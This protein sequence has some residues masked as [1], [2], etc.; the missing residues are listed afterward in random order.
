[1]LPEDERLNQARRVAIQHSEGFGIEHK[2]WL[3]LS[4]PD[5]QVKL[6]RAILALRN[7]DGGWL[8]IGVE[9]GTG[10]TAKNP[11]SNLRVSY[12]ADAIN[13]LIVEF[14]SDPFGVEVCYPDVDGVEVAVLRIPGG[15]KN[16]AVTKKSIGVT[17]LLEGDTIYCRS[18]RGGQVS[19]VKANHRDLGEILE[20]CMRNRELDI[21]TFVR[22]HWEDLTRE[23]SSLQSPPERRLDEFVGTCLS[24]FGQRLVDHNLKRIPMPGQLAVGVAWDGRL[25]DTNSTEHYFTRMIMAHPQKGGWPPW[26]DPR[27]FPGSH[28]KRD[29]RDGAWEGLIAIPESHAQG[30]VFS[31]L[32]FAVWNFSVGLF[33]SGSYVD[34][35]PALGIQQ[36]VSRGET[37]VM[38]GPP[39]WYRRALDRRNI[40]RD[41]ANRLFTA[42]SLVAGLF[43][44]QD[45]PLPENLFFYF[46][47]DSL[48]GRLLADYEGGGFS[49]PANKAMDES[50]VSYT[51]LKMDSDRSV[52]AERTRSVLRP[53]FSAFGGEDLPQQRVDNWLAGFW[54]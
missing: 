32:D 15:V 25:P 39:P 17:K 10:M 42:Q 23:V 30:I 18:M 19:S 27:D 12:D 41:V 47:F 24:K 7:N 13:K 50:I 5:D 51:Q 20:R 33:H 40:V 31:A 9:N 14:S 8:A 49:R 11:P 54:V 26:M 29:V 46:R 4:N 22:R 44:G 35:H 45:A 1:M 34:D 28:C 53:L 38:G 43:K 2:S 21:G 37:W 16:P 48:K 3:D 6:I 36:M 52:I